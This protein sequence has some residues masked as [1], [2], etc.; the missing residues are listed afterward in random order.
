MR[1]WTLVLVALLFLGGTAMAQQIEANRLCIS[2]GSEYYVGGVHYEHL[3]KGVGKYYQSFSHWAAEPAGTPGN[4][5]WPWKIRGWAWGGMQAFLYGPTWYWLTTLTYSIDNPWATSMTWPY[6]LMHFLGFP[7]S[8]FPNNI[9]GRVYPNWFPSAMA[10]RSFVLPSS[11]GG[12]D[13]YM[14]LFAWGDATWQIPS[15]SPFYGWN[16]AFTIPAASA[17]TL[18]SG[19]SLWEWIY[20]SLGPHGQY[21]LLSGNE[22]DCT[23]NTPG[24]A[25]GFK[26][27]NPL[28]L[29]DDIYIYGWL[30]SCDGADTAYDM[31]L[32]LEDAITIPLNLPGTTNWANPYPY[33]GY[34][35]DVGTGTLTPNSSSNVLLFQPQYE[36]YSR[37]GRLRFVLVGSPWVGF[38]PLG[39]PAPCVP[40]G[41]VGNRVPHTWDLLTDTF[42]GI[43]G[44]TQSI[45]PHGLYPACIFG[46]TIGSLGGAFGPLPVPNNF[47][48]VE[49]RICGADT[50]GQPCTA[51]YMITFF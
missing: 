18:P 5:H 30:N 35:F 48:G 43:L 9:H 20:E 32:F 46:T 33:W 2:N 7:H 45:A 40:Y 29:A 42:L 51:S 12:I 22:Y 50:A 26:G 31:C 38:L 19:I 27:V 6:P 36:D 28:I 47:G 10:G 21:S 1:K 49:L 8:G 3:N 14:N 34:Q 4:Y 15:T 23:G 25:G 17:F 39:T 41:P 11:N 44:L 24:T 16:F 37:P 13:T